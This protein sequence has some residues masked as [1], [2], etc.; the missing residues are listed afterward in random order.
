MPHLSGLRVMCAHLQIALYFTNIRHFQW[1]IPLTYD[2]NILKNLSNE[3]ESKN[4]GS[5]K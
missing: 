5:K 1:Q 3:F 2:A 4:L